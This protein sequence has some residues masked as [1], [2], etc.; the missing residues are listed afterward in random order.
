MY[1]FVHISFLFC[2]FFF[3]FL[4]NKRRFHM[5]KKEPHPY[6]GM[7]ILLFEILDK[8]VEKNQIVFFEIFFCL[9]ETQQ[10]LFHVPFAK[11]L[12]HENIHELFGFW[13]AHFP[14]AGNKKKIVN[15]KKNTIFVRRIVWIQRHLDRSTRIITWVIIVAGVLMAHLY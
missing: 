7:R 10:E 6:I 5:F 1:K 13:N 14:K 9:E 8:S 11:D 4:F 12:F 15:L 2:L 3:V